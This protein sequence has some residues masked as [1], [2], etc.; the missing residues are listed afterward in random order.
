MAMTRMIQQRAWKSE[1]SWLRD[2]KH[3]PLEG[4]EAGTP[5]ECHGIE[6]GL[7]L[8]FNVVC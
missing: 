5:T 7:Q 4:R 1:L 6:V 8:K 2:D 3:E